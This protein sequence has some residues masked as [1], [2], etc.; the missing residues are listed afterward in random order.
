MTSWIGAITGSDQTKKQWGQAETETKANAAS[1]LAA[2]Q[3]I[4]NP[5][6]DAAGQKLTAANTGART[7]VG[8]GYDAAHEDYATYY[9]QVQNYLA[10]NYGDAYTAAA[11]GGATGINYLQP[12]MDRGNAAGSLYQSLYDPGAAGAAANETLNQQLVDQN[13]TALD[14]AAKQR[15][16]AQNAA[17]TGTSGREQLAEARAS[18]LALQ[19]LRAEREGMI[20]NDVTRGLGAATTASGIG[21]TTAQILA[22]LHAR[23]GEA[24]A[25]AAQ[26]QANNLSGLDTGQADRLSA[27][28]QWYGGGM[29][30]LD[31]GRTQA[32]SG[33]TNDYWTNYDAAQ[34]AK[35]AAIAGTAGSATQLAMN[36]AG[37]AIQAFSPVPLPRTFNPATGQYSQTQYSTPVGNAWN[38]V[39]SAWNSPSNPLLSLGNGSTPTPS[40]AGG[41]SGAWAAG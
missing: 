36:G 19:Q 41:D 2:Q 12:Y 37:L 10:N 18:G 8:T 31:L 22:N 23:Q 4:I 1:N 33:A 35:H 25:G 32:L 24:Q 9:P 20:N 5:G 27:L 30:N 3:G 28:D 14:Y 11:A 15:L 17:G 39:S 38:G 29:S 7:D 26:T 21:M 34:R 40:Y 13:S 16:A 6:Y